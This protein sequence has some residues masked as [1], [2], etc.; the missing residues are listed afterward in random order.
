VEVGVQPSVEVEV[1]VQPS[2][3]D[4][5][6]NEES[7]WSRLSEL[8]G[9]ETDE[10]LSDT[11]EKEEESG[12]WFPPP[13][14]EEGWQSGSRVAAAAEEPGERPKAPTNAGEA[15]EKEMRAKAREMFAARQ[16]AA[17]QKIEK[18]GPTDRFAMSI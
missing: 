11:D 10:E 17:A 2:V 13:S 12:E 8:R 9:S 7:V 16:R 14:N 4:E 1:E 5:D 6:A 18:G 3:H 15:A